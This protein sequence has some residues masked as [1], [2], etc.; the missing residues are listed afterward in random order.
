MLVMHGGHYCYQLNLNHY[1]DHYF[2]QNHVHWYHLNLLCEYYY[3]PEYHMALWSPEHWNAKNSQNLPQNHIV[4]PVAWEE[5]WLHSVPVYKPR[6]MWSKSVDELNYL[7]QLVLSWYYLSD[8]ANFR[9]H[10][11]N[12]QKHGHNYHRLN[13][14]IS[15]YYTFYYYRC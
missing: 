2:D 4:E 6:R 10:H 7:F 3:H 11:H 12:N 15:L 5:L 13:N 14:W 9:S 8:F 1:S